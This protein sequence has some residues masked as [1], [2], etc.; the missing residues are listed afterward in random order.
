MILPRTFHEGD[1]LAKQYAIAGTNALYK[2]FDIGKWMAHGA[3]VGTQAHT[4][5]LKRAA[6]NIF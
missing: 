1:C 4:A 2:L 3:K 5:P 6:P